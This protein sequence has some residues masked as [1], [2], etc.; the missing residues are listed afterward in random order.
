MG[1]RTNRYS[2]VTTRCLVGNTGAGVPTPSRANR[3]KESTSTGSPARMSRPPRNRNGSQ[4]LIGVSMRQRDIHHGTRPATVPG[5][6]NKNT[7]DPKMA[8][9]R[10]IR[11][12]SACSFSLPWGFIRIATEGGAG[13]GNE[14]RATTFD[15]VAGFGDDTLQ[16][17]EN[18]A[19][20]G[21]AVNGLG[22]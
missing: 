15:E 19:H 8:N 16:D 4:P 7:A 21:F 6:R 10:L 12:H 13:L 17:F 18:L 22:R 9:S 20:A 14:F 5:A 3:A 1:L 11:L 2:P